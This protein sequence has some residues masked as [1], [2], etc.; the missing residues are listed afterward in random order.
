MIIE[1]L[2]SYYLGLNFIKSSVLFTFQFVIFQLFN[3][4]HTIN[5]DCFYRNKL[6]L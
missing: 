5:K 6:I 3:K 1:G 2:K 4:V